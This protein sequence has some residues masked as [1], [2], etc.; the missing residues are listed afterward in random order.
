MGI[1]I[2]RKFLVLNKEWLTSDL[3]G[4]QI[5]QGYLQNSVKSVV[6]IRVADTQG[7]LTVKASTAI[8][9][10]IDNSI[11]GQKIQTL[12]RL[13]FEYKIPFDD[14]LE[15]LKLCEKP[16]IEKVRY[17]LDFMGFEWSI[18]IFEGENLGLVLA[19]IELKS[20]DQEFIKPAWLGKEVTDDPKYLNSNLIKNPFRAIK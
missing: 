13:E 4:I 7:F 8:D 6:R 15:M 18:D 19:E 5:K 16:I 1:E 3:K 20:E 10:E 2:E 11:D 9:H 17:T 14:A 12:S